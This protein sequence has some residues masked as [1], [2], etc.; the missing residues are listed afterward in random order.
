MRHLSDEELVHAYYGEGGLDHLA[1]CERCRE[2]LARIATTLDAADAFAVPER[3]EEYGAEVW[4]R[5]APSL[6]VDPTARPFWAALWSPHR[7]ATV[8]AV[9]V[10]LLA[11]FFAG[12][13]SGY[14]SVAERTPAP[15][16]SGDRQNILLA[17]LSAHL[18]RSERVLLEVMNRPPEREMDLREEQTRAADLVASSRLYRQAATA[19]GDQ[20]IAAVLEDLERALMEIARSSPKLS[21]DEFQNLRGRIEAQGIV[22]KVRVTDSNLQARSALL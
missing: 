9:A 6:S 15:I 20:D 18:D 4:A 8:G 10:L 16:S 14:P 5:L 7:W 19:A 11:A 17:A 12:R 13:F 2:A 21:R 1:G 3:G 22:F